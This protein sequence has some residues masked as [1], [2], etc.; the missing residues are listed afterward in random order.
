[1]HQHALTELPSHVVYHV[2]IWIS[3]TA[4]VALAILLVFYILHQWHTCL[5]MQR[6]PSLFCSF[7]HL[8]EK[9]S[10]ALFVHIRKNLLMSL[11]SFSRLFFFSGMQ[12]FASWLE[13]NL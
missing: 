12:V 11:K 8:L 7:T 9:V 4:G 2:K 13:Y 1:M 10:I 3:D 5:F 6:Q